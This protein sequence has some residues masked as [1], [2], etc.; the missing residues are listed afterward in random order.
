M[1][2]IVMVISIVI[3]IVIIIIIVVIVITRRSRSLAQHD[4]QDSRRR[5]KPEVPVRSSL[6]SV[7]AIKSLSRRSLP[8]V[9]HHILVKAIDARSRRV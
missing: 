4:P 8:S 7:P 5:R 2:I 1:I 3:V 6:R 9:L